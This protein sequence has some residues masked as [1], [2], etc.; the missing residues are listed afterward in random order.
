M[1]NENTVCKSCGTENE[2]EYIYCKNCGEKLFKEEEKEE[3]KK[4]NYYENRNYESGT[5]QGGYYNQNS[6]SGYNY[7]SQYQRPYNPPYRTAVVDSIDGIPI[8]EIG[9]FVGKKAYK[10]IPKFS[11][12][13]LTNSKVSWSWPVAV[14]GLIFGPIGAAIWF[15]YRKMYK[16]GLILICIGLVLGVVTSFASGNSTKIDSSLQIVEDALENQNNELALETLK[17]ILSSKDFIRLSVGRI[18]DN[19]INLAVMVLSGLFANY[20]YKKHTVKKIKQYRSSS[21]DPRYYRIGLAAF[22]GTSTGMAILGVVALLLSSS[23]SSILIST[24]LK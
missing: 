18:I 13:T 5:N 3:F 9:D 21:I 7:N 4:K 2:P 16:I 19:G 20:L 6:N 8:D 14:L 12:L 23:L 1:N 22:G 11:K 15:L 10:Y 17:D 24:F